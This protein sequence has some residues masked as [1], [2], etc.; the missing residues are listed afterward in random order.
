MTSAFKFKVPPVK[1]MPLG[2]VDPPTI[3]LKLTSPLPADTVRSVLPSMVLLNET[4]LSVV[5]KSG[6]L[7]IDKGP[8]KVWAPVVV[9]LL[10]M[11]IVPVVPVVARLVSGVAPTMPVKVTP[12]DPVA[13]T[14]F[15]ALSKVS[16]KVTRSSDVV[17]VES[18]ANKTG[19]FKRTM[20]SESTFPVRVIFPVVPVVSKLVMF[21]PFPIVLPKVAP[22]DPEAMVNAPAPDTSPLKVT[23]LLVVVRVGDPESV[24]GPVYV[25]TPEVVMF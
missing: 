1:L 10:L 18:A 20:P 14:K 3:P 7:V 22:P 6:E 16:E 8:V 23:R 12:P 2:W 24:T 21:T 9:T 13:T 19:P 11:E 17:I 25:W 4:A 15:C 5:V